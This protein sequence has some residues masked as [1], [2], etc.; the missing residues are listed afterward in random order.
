L[1]LEKK[2]D[3]EKIA[4]YFDLLGLDWETYKDRNFDTHLSG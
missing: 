4:Y 3:E 1:D 2:F